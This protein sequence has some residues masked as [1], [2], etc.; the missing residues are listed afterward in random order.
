MYQQSLIDSW[1]LIE[2][3]TD[4][5]LFGI[6]VSIFRSRHFKFFLNHSKYQKL[7]GKKH[8]T[9]QCQLQVSAL[10]WSIQSF[11]VLLF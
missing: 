10:G 8:L 5:N 3:G 11:F 6:N 2:K 7:S 9:D 1:H 4:H